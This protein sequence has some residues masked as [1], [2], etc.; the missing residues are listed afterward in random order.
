MTKQETAEVE[1][2]VRTLLQRLSIELP[3]AAKAEASKR[4]HTERRTETKDEKP[5][6]KG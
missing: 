4:S 3:T 1:E 6:P 5:N 2:L